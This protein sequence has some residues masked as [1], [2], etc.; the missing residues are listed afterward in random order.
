MFDI[1]GLSKSSQLVIYKSVGLR[2]AM[3]LLL[4]FLSVGLYT[5]KIYVFQLTDNGAVK[6]KVCV[7]VD[8]AKQENCVGSDTYY[9]SLRSSIKS[10]LEGSAI[11]AALGGSLWLIWSRWNVKNWQR[12]LADDKPVRSFRE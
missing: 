8:Y 1:F 7:D 2:V 10:T 6:N 12:I 11:F 5:T 9:T 4:F 3:F